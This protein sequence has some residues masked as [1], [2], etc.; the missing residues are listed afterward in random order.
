M[1]QRA[2]AFTVSEA[3]DELSDL[4]VAKLDARQEGQLPSK[5]WEHSYRRVLFIH[6]CENRY[7]VVAFRP[8]KTHTQTY[9]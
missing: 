6:R 1:E 8:N 7:G 3:L 9:S 2:T 5:Q 4:I